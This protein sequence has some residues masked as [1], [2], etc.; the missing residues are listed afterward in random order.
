VCIDERGAVD[1][2]SVLTR[3]DEAPREALAHA[4]RTWRYQPVREG[5]AAIA[6]CFVTTLRFMAK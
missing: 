2:V 5:D 1:S 6:A 3:I 4:I